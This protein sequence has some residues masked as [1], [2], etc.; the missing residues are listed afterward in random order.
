MSVQ[1]FGYRGGFDIIKIDIIKTDSGLKC[2][3]YN[4]I[5]PVNVSSL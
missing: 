1:F 2:P 3:M 5:I 4:A